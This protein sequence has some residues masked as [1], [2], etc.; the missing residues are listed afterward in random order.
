MSVVGQF[1]SSNSLRASRITKI[2]NREKTAATSS[3]TTTSGHAEPVSVTPTAAT[4]TPTLPI[5]SLRE[6]TYADR[7]S[8]SS[9]RCRQSNTRQKT[10]A[11]S[12]TRPPAPSRRRMAL[13]RGAG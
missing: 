13:I 8:M 11:A 9:P 5:T 10:L 12:A 4:S 1:E 3:P 7:I 2:A 6:Q